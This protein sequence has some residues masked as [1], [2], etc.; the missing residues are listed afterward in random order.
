M[1]SHLRL[2]NED[3]DYVDGIHTNIGFFGFL[4]PFGDADYYVG[5]GGP[6]QDGCVNRNVFEACKY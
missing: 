2:T 6:I 3:A 4:A 1:P 5:F